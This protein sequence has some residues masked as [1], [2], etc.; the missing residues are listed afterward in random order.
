MKTLAVQLLLSLP[1]PS[2]EFFRETHASPEWFATSDP[3]GV[4]LGSGG[5]TVHLLAEAWRATSGELPF[6]E[7]LADSPKLIIHGG[8]QSRRLPA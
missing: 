6:E 5:G 3:P 1:V 4:K 8:G 7:W 2:V